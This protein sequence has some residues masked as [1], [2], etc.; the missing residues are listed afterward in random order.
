MVVTGQRG[1]LRLGCWSLLVLAF[2]FPTARDLLQPW[3]LLHGSL[4]LGALRMVGKVKVIGVVGGGG[5]IPG[6]AL[7]QMGAGI[8]VS[9]LNLPNSMGQDAY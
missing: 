3:P 7:G 4:A 2:P 9:I 5:T 6:R 8:S 1:P